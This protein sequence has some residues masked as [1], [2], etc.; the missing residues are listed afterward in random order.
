MNLLLIR[1]AIAEDRHPRHWP[2]DEDRPLTQRG[3]RRFR[4]AATGLGT[5]VPQVDRLITSPF[6]RTHQTATI[7]E[8]QLAWPSAEVRDHL[9][10]GAPLAGAVALLADCDRRST[11]AVVGH[12]PMMSLLTA[13]FTGGT[14]SSFALD[15]RRGGAAS[16]EFDA[17]PKVGGGA[18]RWFMPPR[19]LRALAD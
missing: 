5:L 3:I 9:A 7:L 14:G 4:T 16:I 10:G 18:L 1:H 6:V 13:A 19:M 15:W 17:A 2:N 12:E 11:V 8:D